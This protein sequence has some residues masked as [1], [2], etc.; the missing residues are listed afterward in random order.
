MTVQ[1]VETDVS[2]SGKLPE[3]PIRTPLADMSR[4]GVWWYGLKW[5]VGYR[6]IGPAS[7]TRKVKGYMLYLRWI[8]THV[9]GW[10]RF[11]L[12]RVGIRAPFKATVS[13]KEFRV[14]SAAERIEFSKQLK[15]TYNPLPF[16]EEILGKRSGV[17]KF[18][19]KDK[20]LAFPYAGD[21]NGTLVVLKEFFLSEPYAR[22]DVAGKDV[23]DIGATFG[24]TPIYFAIRGAKRVIALE[25]YPATYALAKGNIENNGFG[26]RITLLN[27]GAGRTGVMRLTRQPVNFWANAVPSDD[28]EDIHF[29]SLK[30][31]VTRFGLE[32]AALKLHGEGSEY[33]L[34][35][36][37][38]DE[39]LAHS[40]QIVLKYHWGGRRIADRLVKAGFEIVEMWDLHFSYNENSSFPR[41]E[42]GMMWARM[43]E[44]TSA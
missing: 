33:A 17:F 18:R 41:Y 5:R 34:L 35:E 8:M 15:S 38:S 24:D 14:R 6:L 7:W 1:G 36:S 22:L 21:R 32:K 39:D 4:I 20:P 44:R 16:E 43:P 31:L 29:N 26:D 30:D 42:A 10:P 28:G 40:P 12:W 2:P 25:P 23:L 27:E 19:Y 11:L 9:K 3:L 13:G 37:A